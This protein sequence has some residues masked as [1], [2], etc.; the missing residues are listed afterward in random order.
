MKKI[1]RAGFSLVMI[2]SILNCVSIISGCDN[3]QD[4]LDTFQ[5]QIKNIKLNTIVGKN[6]YS[7]IYSFEYEGNK[8]IMSKMSSGVSL[9]CI[10]CDNK[11]NNIINKKEVK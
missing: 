4:R 5:Q 1:I 10:T 8:Y 6:L 9:I 2:G 7:G 3:D 11:C